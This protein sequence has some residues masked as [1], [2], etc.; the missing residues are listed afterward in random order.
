MNF[1]GI[2]PGTKYI[3]IAV[4]NKKKEILLLETLEIENKKTLAQK[5]KKIVKKY[6]P[7]VCAIESAFTKRDPKTAL[8][9]GEIRGVILFI[10]ESNNRKIIDITTAKWKKAITAFGRA[11]KYQVKYML[12]NLLEKKI[13]QKLS[14]HQIDALALA[15]YAYMQCSTK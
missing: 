1:L 14:E 7:K 5:I 4:L 3:G 10:L 6:N 2:D 13:P 12:E 9:L 11:K 8:K 15:Y